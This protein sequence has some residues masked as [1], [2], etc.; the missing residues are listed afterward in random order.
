[1][2]I[3]YFFDYFIIRWVNTFFLS[4]RLRVKIKKEK[5]FNADCCCE[6][7]DSCFKAMANGLAIIQW[8][9]IMSCIYARNFRG[10]TMG[11]QKIIKTKC[12]KIIRKF[13]NRL[14]TYCKSLFIFLLKQS[15]CSLFIWLWHHVLELAIKIS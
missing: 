9:L 5:K 14:T 10:G 1:M 6:E 2:H 13:Y 15:F 7:K 11:S 8:L 4:S 12:L 3:V